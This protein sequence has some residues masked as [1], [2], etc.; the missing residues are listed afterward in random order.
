M[1]LPVAG[2]LRERLKSTKLSGMATA[3]SFPAEWQRSSSNRALTRKPRRPGW[4]DLGFRVGL[5]FE[6]GSN[7]FGIFGMLPA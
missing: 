4:A 7:D 5:A 2:L 3:S 6:L 1:S